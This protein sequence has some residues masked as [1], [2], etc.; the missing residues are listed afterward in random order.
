MSKA[1]MNLIEANLLLSCMEFGAIAATTNERH[2]HAIPDLYLT[3]I[4]T[5]LGINT[6]KL[7]SWHIW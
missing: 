6:G 2:F 5:D 4:S 7:M 1:R 3:D